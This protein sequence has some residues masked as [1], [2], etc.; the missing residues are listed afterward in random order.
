M[1]YGSRIGVKLNKKQIQEV[2]RWLDHPSQNSCPFHFPS[3]RH[4][5]CLTWFGKV[6]EQFCPCDQYSF[7]FV[8]LMAQKMI[9]YSKRKTGG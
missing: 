8:K 9:D 6:T 7:K 5:I 4:N 3:G 2:K 1:R